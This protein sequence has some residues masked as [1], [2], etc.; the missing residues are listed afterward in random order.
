[1][2]THD[3]IWWLQ[4]SIL[5]AKIKFRSYVCPGGTT[6]IFQSKVIDKND[7]AQ[8]QKR[9][10]ILKL[11]ILFISIVVYSFLSSEKNK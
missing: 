2:N 1:M 9:E 5:L 4:L 6:S 8:V 11:Y 3:A 7:M 10:H